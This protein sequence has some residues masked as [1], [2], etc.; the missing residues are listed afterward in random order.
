ML[1]LNFLSLFFLMP[2]LSSLSFSLSFF[3]FFLGL[4]EN[5]INFFLPWRFCLLSLWVFNEQ[6]SIVLYTSFLLRFGL[7]V[8]W[9]S[10]VFSV[11][12]SVCGRPASG[13]AISGYFVSFLFGFSWIKGDVNFVWAIQE[14]LDHSPGSPFISL[15]ILKCHLCLIIYSFGLSF[16]VGF[17]TLLSALPTGS[18]LVGV[19][20]RISL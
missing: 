2:M 1:L 13:D 12:V 5:D 18:Q 14:K 10:W 20:Q 4:F 3:F 11:P 6:Y 7:A 17:V 9:L 16:F 8:L 15:D 19:S